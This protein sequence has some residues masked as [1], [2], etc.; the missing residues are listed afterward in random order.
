MHR[1]CCILYEIHHVTKAF[2]FRT[3]IVM[4]FGTKRELINKGNSHVIRESKNLRLQ[5][6]F[7][8][9]IRRVIKTEVSTVPLG[10]QVRLALD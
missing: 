7:V 9:F 10:V 1:F 3:P 8:Q 5:F 4:K 6:K 2:T